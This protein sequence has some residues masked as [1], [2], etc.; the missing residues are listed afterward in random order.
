MDYGARVHKCALG[1][2]VLVQSFKLEKKYKGLLLPIPTEAWLAE[3]GSAST[4]ACEPTLG[5][6][7]G[8][9]RNPRFPVRFRAGPLVKVALMSK[10]SLGPKPH[11]KAT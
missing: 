2:L 5:E 7:L 11:P 6:A 8:N 1:R 4:R 9:A 10:A 3:L